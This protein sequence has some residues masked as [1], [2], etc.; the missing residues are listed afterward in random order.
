M[1]ARGAKI[2]TLVVDDEAHART[3][4]RQLL[5]GEPDFEIIAECANGRQAVETIQRNKPDLMFLDVQ[6]PRLSGLDVCETA[7]AAGAPMPLVIFVTA[8]DEYAL[9]AFD[10]HA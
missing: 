9:K 1:M 2:R 10:L 3:R 5:K 6:M 8:Y 7:A 4:I